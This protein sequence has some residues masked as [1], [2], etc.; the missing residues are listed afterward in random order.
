MG[1]GECSCVERDPDRSSGLW[2]S[3]VGNH[4]EG[5]LGREQGNKHPIL[6]LPLVPPAGDSLWLNPTE[7]QRTREPLMHSS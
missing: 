2:L 6:L 4:R 1:I 7:R 3:D 5:K